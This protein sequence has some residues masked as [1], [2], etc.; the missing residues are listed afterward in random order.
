MKNL[1][2]TIVIALAAI[3]VPISTV[4]AEMATKDEVLTVAKNWVSL[5]IQKKGDWGG[6]ETAQIESIQEFKRGERVIGYFCRV[7]PKGY[8]V[9]SLLKELAPVKA[10]SATCNLKPEIDEGLTDLIKGKMEGILDFLQQQL[11]PDKLAQ[12]LDTLQ[13][14]EINYRPAWDILAGKLGGMK[15]VGESGVVAMNYAGGE[16]LLTSAWHQGQP[17]NRKC[18]GPEPDDDCSEANC[19]VGCV[20]L[21]GAQVMRYWAWPPGY[22]WANMPDE[23]WIGSSEIKKEAVATLCLMVGINANADYCDG[24]CST[25]AYTYQPGKR[26][27]LEVFEEDFSYSDEAD[28]RNREDYTALQWWTR[29]RNNLDENRPLPYRVRKHAIV[30]DGW[31]EFWQDGTY[32]R[33]YHMNYGWGDNGS[34]QDGCN[35]WYTLDEL[36]L[37]GKDI[38]LMLV[39][40]R[41]SGSLGGLL[42]GK[43][44]LPSYFD[45]DAVGFDAT[46]SGP[47][48]YRQFLPGVT[49]KCI[50]LGG[51]IF[52]E[53]PLQRLFSIKGTATG[54]KVAGIQIYN[55]AINLYENGSLRFH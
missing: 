9:V 2:N 54:G 19:A 55:G 43:N 20:P 52:F 46:F 27:L 31:Q 12:S 34:C 14:L 13:V 38:E 37:G 26:D 47:Y 24:D 11:G 28:N 10:Y 49:V 21:A 1:T 4:Q 25:S 35:T 23:C 6:S 17:Y 5:I 32:V 40:I 51:Q 33:Q 42:M 22:D 16:P 39:Q 3:L 7:Q 53:G 8:I 36:H 45:Q 30:C 18:P 44:W 48:M 50:G 29:I 41:P 15:V